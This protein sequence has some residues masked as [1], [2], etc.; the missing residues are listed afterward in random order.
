MKTPRFNGCPCSELGESRN[1]GLGDTALRC[2]WAATDSRTLLRSGCCHPRRAVERP[3][4][5]RVRNPYV[6]LL[7]ALLLTTACVGPLPVPTLGDPP[8]GGGG[9]GSHSASL[10]PE[11][12]FMSVGDVIMFTYVTNTGV[13]PQDVIWVN[14]NPAVVSIQTPVEGCGSRCGI[15]RALAAGEAQLRPFAILNGAKFEAP[16]RLVVR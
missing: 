15:V 10:V 16:R 5:T 14:E 13:V 11:I 1:L 2:R 8:P 12:S 3:G 7:V 6:R 4:L 9:S